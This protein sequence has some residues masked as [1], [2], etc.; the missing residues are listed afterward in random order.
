MIKQGDE[1]TQ[2]QQTSAIL[3]PSSVLLS[4]IPSAIIAD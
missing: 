2:I 3:P 1:N 4:S